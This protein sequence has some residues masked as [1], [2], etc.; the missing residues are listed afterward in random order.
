MTGGRG[1]SSP[2]NSRGCSYDSAMTQHKVCAS[3]HHHFLGAC[4]LLGQTEPQQHGVKA[5]RSSGSSPQSDR[6]ETFMTHNPKAQKGS[7]MSVPTH[8]PDVDRPTTMH[9]QPRS[10]WSRGK[11]LP[12][13]LQSIL[14]HQIKW[15]FQSFALKCPFAQ[16][17]YVA[18]SGSGNFSV[19]SVISHFSLRWMLG[20]CERTYL[21]RAE[22]SQSNAAV[23]SHACDNSVPVPGRT[24]AGHGSHHPPHRTPWRLRAA[25]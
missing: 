6:P 8:M 2:R 7:S 9:P 12:L 4:C 19:I 24:R 17:C 16:S 21:R 15:V 25:T 14:S 13:S 20:R 11:P 22:D 5:F 18:K 23:Q 1:Q 10:A 3:V